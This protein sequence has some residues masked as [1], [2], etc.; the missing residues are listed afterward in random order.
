VP[1]RMRIAHRLPIIV[2]N[3]GSPLRFGDLPEFSGHSDSNNV[4][5]ETGNDTAGFAW[6][7]FCLTK[8][9]ETIRNSCKAKA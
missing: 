3:L 5:A 2:P 7:T 8:I 1:P 9:G 4:S 6:I